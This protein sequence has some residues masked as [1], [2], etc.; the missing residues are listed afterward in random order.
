GH[1]IAIKIEID[2]G[3]RLDVL[4]D[5]HLHAVDDGAE[6]LGFELEVANGRCEAGKIGAPFAKINRVD[7]APPLLQLSQPGICRTLVVGDVVDRPA[8]RVNLE[9]RLALA[10]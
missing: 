4:P 8:K 1:A 7:I 6:V 9:H 5:I 3:G 2:K 10:V